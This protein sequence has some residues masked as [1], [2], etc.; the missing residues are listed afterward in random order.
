[1]LDSCQWPTNSCANTPSTCVFSRVLPPQETLE[2]AADGQGAGGAQQP[3][4]SSSGS[5]GLGTGTVAAKLAAEAARWA[6]LTLL[7]LQ[8]ED[9]PGDR[10]SGAAGL[11]A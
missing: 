11:T 9:Y 1:M 7:M 6:Q 8:L 10:R 4:N 3:D 2:E 5:A